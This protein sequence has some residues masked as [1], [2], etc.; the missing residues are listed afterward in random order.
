[1]QIQNK[2]FITPASLFRAAGVSPT[3]GRKRLQELEANGEIKPDKTAAG[4]KKLSIA[5]AKRL[6]EAL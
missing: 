3:T 5:E 2:R 4:H 6:A 1:M